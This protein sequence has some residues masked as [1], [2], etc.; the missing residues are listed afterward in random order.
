[1]KL[2]R[3]KTNKE[4]SLE[5]WVA[6]A[7]PLAYLESLDEFV[8]RNDLLRQIGDAPISEAVKQ[9]SEKLGQFQ[10]DEHLA[11][12]ALTCFHESALDQVTKNTA[13]V[14][15][16]TKFAGMSIQIGKMFVG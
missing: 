2:Y 9:Q 15:I 14:A 1:V 12:N 13:V 11:R 4:L 7:S 8:Q 6:I 5:E 3:E 16:S 10:L